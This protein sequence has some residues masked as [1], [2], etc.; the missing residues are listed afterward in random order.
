M[1]WRKRTYADPQLGTL[2]YSHGMWCGE[3]KGPEGSVLSL[4]MSGDRDRPDSRMLERARELVV[5]VDAL[6]EHA[7][8]YLQARED[9]REFAEGNGD[10]VLDALDVGPEEGSFD[11][12]FGFTAW[13]DGYVTV[14]FAAAQPTDVI[15]G[16]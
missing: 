3:V 14:R 5:S 7:W 11:L 10:F 1:F 9:V 8:E 6:K 15:M 2:T 4:G 12:S 16:D 13:P